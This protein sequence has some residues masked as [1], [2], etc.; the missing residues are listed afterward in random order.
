MSVTTKIIG[1][2]STAVVFAGMAF[3]QQALTCNTSFTVGGGGN[4]IS[5]S[6]PIELRSEGATELV[7]DELANCAA[8]PVGSTL[9]QVTATLSA[10]GLQAITSKVLSTSTGVT[11][12]TLTV[13]GATYYQGI[14]TGNTITFGTVAAPVTFP[15]V[16]FTLQVSNVRVN[17]TGQ[18]PNNLQPVTET[19]QL[20]AQGNGLAAVTNLPAVT[21]GNQRNSLSVKGSAS[22]PYIAPGSS[23]VAGTAMNATNYLVCSGGGASAFSVQISELFPGAFKTLVQNTLGTTTTASSLTVAGIPGA[24]AG[25]L[26]GVGATGTGVANSG[27]RI[28]LV[29]SGIPTNATL[30]V[31]TSVTGTGGAGFQMNLTSSETGV[32]SQVTTPSGTTAGYAPITNGQATYEVLASDY[33]AI[34]TFTVT[35]IVTF[36]GNAV[37]APAGPITVAVS[38]APSPATNGASLASPIPSIP[39]FANTSTTLSGSTFSACQTTLLFPF[40]TNQQGFDTGLVVANTGLDY[41]NPTGKTTSVASG[42]SGACTINFYG[43]TGAEGGTNPGTTPITVANFPSSTNK[44]ITTIAPGTTHADLLSNVSPGFQGYAI[45]VCPFLYARGY[46]FIEMGLGT[47]T[48]LAEGYLADVIAA[49]RSPLSAYGV[50]VANNAPESSGN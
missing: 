41:L 3:G 37:T 29:F 36:S 47:G 49:S 16:P 11:E 44:P 30:I 34:G 9:G 23:S 38:Y 26:V 13:N 15:T 20:I 24:E 45:A 48:G 18:Y 35:P 10:T 21:V 39:Y 33:T 4:A 2:A 27:T 7:S 25:S 32:F 46:A 12:A 40:I 19:L 5:P 31:P 1:L 43:S 14:V 28:K 17:A 50:T 42:Q 22:T 6:V 8:A